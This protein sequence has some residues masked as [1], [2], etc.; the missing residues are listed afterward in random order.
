MMLC[1]TVFIQGHTVAIASTALQKRRGPGITRARTSSQLS[2]IDSH[3]ERGSG[4]SRM[5]RGNTVKAR[6]TH[7]H[8]IPL[9]STLRLENTPVPCTPQPPTALFLSP[10]PS[11]Q[12]PP[13]SLPVRP[14]FT[15]RRTPHPFMC[16]IHAETKGAL[17]QIPPSTHSMLRTCVRHR[18]C[19]YPL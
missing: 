1:S 2:I 4:S 3:T 7:H 15:R 16:K 5:K 10:H 18:T 11:S 8:R 17:S 14:S 9:I 12:L 19:L 13:S 6:T